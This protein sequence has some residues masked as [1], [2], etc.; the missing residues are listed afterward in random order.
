MVVKK[1]KND[2]LSMKTDALNVCLHKLVK[3]IWIV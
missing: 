1:A 3:I 2:L